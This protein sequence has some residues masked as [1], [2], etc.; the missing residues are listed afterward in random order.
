MQVQEY[1]VPAK[2]LAKQFLNAGVGAC[3]DAI[4]VFAGSGGGPL[5]SRLWREVSWFHLVA[6]RV[7]AKYLC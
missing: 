3:R 7:G 6:G 5:L 4:L 1:G 2:K